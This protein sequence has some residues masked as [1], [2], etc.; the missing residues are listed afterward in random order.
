MDASKYEP[1][2]RPHQQKTRQPRAVYTGMPEEGH[3]E[4]AH[5]AEAK[6]PRKEHQ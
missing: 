3:L 4:V 1:E 5:E 6:Q 2:Q